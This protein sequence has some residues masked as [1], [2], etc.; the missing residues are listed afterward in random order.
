[1]TITHSKG[2]Y[3]IHFAAKADLATLLPHQAPILTDEKVASLFPEI[4]AEHPAFVIPAG[5]EQKNLGR[6]QEAVEWLADHKVS[7]SSTVVALGG[8]VIGD[9]AGFV[10]ASYMR[11]VKFIQVPTT[12]LAQVDSSV[13]GKVGVDLPQGKNLVGAFHPPASVVVCTDALATLDER[14]FVNGM[15]EVWKYG[16]IRDPELVGELTELQ[17][18]PHHPQ[19]EAIVRRCIRHKRDVVEADEMEVT[20]LRATLNFGHTIG[21]AIEQ[22]TAYARYLHG[23]AI[24]IGMVAEAK[25][26]EIIGLAEPGTTAQVRDSLASQGLPVMLDEEIDADTLVEAMRRDKKSKDGKLAF[27]L[28]TRVGECKL[29][30]DVSER[31]VRLALVEL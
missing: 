19:L 30:E 3:D 26:S 21:H 17:L 4:L 2:A 25:L 6:F 11:G 18:D 23:E 29:V 20:G 31:D 7:R 15:A 12:L 9:L 10:A 5:E 1:M 16:F 8:G 14:Q 28:L 13:G 27:S 22:A 24:S